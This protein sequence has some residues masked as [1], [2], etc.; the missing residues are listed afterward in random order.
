MVKKHTS[1]RKA[2]KAAEI[3]RDPNASKIAR[4]LAGSAL[5][6]TDPKAVT[7]PEM[8]EKAAKALESGSTSKETKSLAG[9]VLTQA[10]HSARR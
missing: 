8:A 1:S 6:Q 3:L 7:S 4:S 5:R 9:T 2:T 10:E